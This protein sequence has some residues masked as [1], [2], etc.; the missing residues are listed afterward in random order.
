MTFDTSAFADIVLAD[1]HDV[2]TR[3]GGLWERAPHVILFL[4]HFG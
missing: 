4:R 1:S 3:L 2:D